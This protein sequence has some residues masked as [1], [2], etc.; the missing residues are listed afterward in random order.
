MHL[1]NRSALSVRPTQAFIDWI[2]SLEPTE[3]DEDL[4]LDDVER[5]STVYLIPEMDTENALHAYVHER[6]VD[7]LEHE[8]GAWEDDE[9]QWPAPRDWALFKEFVRLEYS[10]LTVDLDGVSPL[11]SDDMGDDFVNEGQDD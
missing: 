6:F 4:L 9:T 8:F 10:Y 5:E 2:N 3:G 7:I 1:V 11:S